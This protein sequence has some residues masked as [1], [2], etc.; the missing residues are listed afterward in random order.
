MSNPKP[1]SLIPKLITY[2]FDVK[3]IDLDNTANFTLAIAQTGRTSLRTSGS[4]YF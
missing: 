4:G 3:I 2:G 1:Y